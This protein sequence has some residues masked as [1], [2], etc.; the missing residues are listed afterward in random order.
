MIIEK[1][2]NTPIYIQIQDMIRDMISKGELKAGDSVFSENE[3]SER[4]GVSRQTVRKAYNELEKAGVFQ[5]VHG[6][7]TFI[8]D[9]FDAADNSK[10][11]RAKSMSKMIGV[12]F[13]EI[14]NFFPKILKGIEEKA[15]EMGY[16][17]NLMLNDNFE[18]EAAAI[19]KLLDNNVDGIILTPF[20]SY[21]NSSVSNYSLLTEQGIPFVMVGKPPKKIQSDAVFCDDVQG[22]YLAIK[23]LIDEGYKFIVHLTNSQNDREAYE[24]RKEG[25]M[26]AVEEMIGASQVCII[27][28]FDSKW[29]SQLRGIIRDINDKM[30]VFT[31][32]D[33][34]AAIA[35]NIIQSEGRRIASD[36]GVLGFNNSPICESLSVKL[37]SIDH[38]K[39]QI[40]HIAFELLEEKLSSRQ[41][42]KRNGSRHI[43]LQ[44]ELIRRESI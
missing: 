9:S 28:F 36:V 20:R 41:E 10:P 37:S 1:A 4:L 29:E 32:T 39:Q 35:Y 16:S 42:T 11:T 8:S 13:P 44:T 7:G 17:I 33:E 21:G 38:P 22:S 19:R 3:L 5:R 25:Y 26:L 6:K 43:I 31:N 12:M 18:K 15:S 24:E 27:D 2:S 40:G 30:A 34:L 23:Q 14:T